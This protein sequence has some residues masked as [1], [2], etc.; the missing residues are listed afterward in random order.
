MDFKTIIYPKVAARV[1]CVFNEQDVQIAL[2]AELY[3][4]WRSATELFASEVRGLYLDVN[5]Y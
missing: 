2:R 3:Q 1:V 5:H 4:P